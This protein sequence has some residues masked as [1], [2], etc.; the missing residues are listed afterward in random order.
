MGL[1]D[2]FKKSET[3]ATENVSRGFHEVAIQELKHLNSDSVQVSFQV[4]ADLRKE[5]TFIPGQY[6]NLELI[7]NGKKE[8]RSYSICSGASEQLAVAV[9]RIDKGIVSN[10][11]NDQKTADFPIWIS[12]PEGN[13]KLS[14]NAKN[15]VCIAAGSG[16]TPI[17]SMAK[18]LS[19]AAQM[20][21]FYGSKQKDSILFESELANLS[22]VHCTHF[23]SQEEREGY[24][25]G[26]ITKDSFTKKLKANLSL[27][28]ADAF[29]IC[30]PT[31]LVQEMQECLAFFGVAKDKIHIELFTPL[32]ST[33]PVET[34]AFSGESKVKVMIDGETASFTMK[35]EQHSVLELAE[36]NGLD[37]PYSCRGGVCCS[38]RAKVLKGSAKMRSNFSLTDDE[39]NQGYILTC[40]AF[41]TSDELIV[42]F[43]E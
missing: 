34:V 42:S 29:Y 31:G 18:H 36:K 19:S 37:A 2:R 40:Q 41:P 23:L 20:H 5:F 30:G 21:L 10:F 14:L 13:F 16:I 11:L 26:R 38:C 24:F 28:Q 12:K 8:R 6:I 9:K 4:P 32:E 27:L 3:S 25:T 1:F 39:V 7:I 33:A 22:N 15:I 17:L 35:G 43:D